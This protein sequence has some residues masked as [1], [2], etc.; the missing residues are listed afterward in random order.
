MVHN[1]SAACPQWDRIESIARSVILTGA[2]ATEPTTMHHRNSTKNADKLY[3]G[4]KSKVLRLF[5]G[6]K[7]EI[8]KRVSTGAGLRHRRS[9]MQFYER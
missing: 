3:N 2:K 6:Y 4:I 7:R 5:F 9:L 1:P 8:Q